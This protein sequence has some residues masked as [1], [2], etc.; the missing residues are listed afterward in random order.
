MTLTEKLF[1]LQDTKYRSFQQ[2]L[3]PNIS[4]ETII[5]VRTADLRRLSREVGDLN[6]FLDSLPHTYFEENQIHGFL[7]EREKDFDTAVSRVE[8]FL[9]YVDNWASCDQLRPKVF[10]KY[11]KD[12]LPYIRKWLS[13]CH[14]Y[15]IRFGISMLM[16]HFLDE[17]FQVEYLDWVANVSHEDYYVKMMIAWY[18]AT[19]LA[20]QYD[21]ALPYIAEQRLEPWTHKKAIQKAV[22]SY[23][24]SKARKETLKVYRA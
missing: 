23:R 7:L 10:A 6:S 12:L 2:K 11:N 3:I 13:S 16:C 21:A 8:A 14:P 4:P 19:A 18:F 1:S 24:I 22:E 17:D 20:K 5:G 15:T 9:P